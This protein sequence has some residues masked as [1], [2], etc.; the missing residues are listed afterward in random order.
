MLL[1][2]RKRLGVRQSPPLPFLNRNHGL[3][4]KLGRL[5]YR[6]RGNVAAAA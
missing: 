1:R 3:N 2:L 5:M 4:I 6:L